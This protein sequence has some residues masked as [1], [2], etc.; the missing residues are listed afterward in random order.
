MIW[1]L[2]TELVYKFLRQ[3]FHFKNC[4]VASSSWQPLAGNLLSPL[5]S[6]VAS[7]IFAQKYLKLKKC[8]APQLQI[9][10]FL[11]HS[12]LLLLSWEHSLD[13]QVNCLFTE[14]F[15]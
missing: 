12:G 6:G 15:L 11:E 8:G 10:G 13:F 4:G 9:I 2:W 7:K 14:V 5:A 1:K 3:N